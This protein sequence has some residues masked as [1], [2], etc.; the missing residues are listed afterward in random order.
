[1][2]E[3]WKQ[4]TFVDQMT[5]FHQ[6]STDAPSNFCEVLAIQMLGHAVGYEPANCLQPKEVKH[7]CY[8]LFIGESTI[9]RKSTTQDF[10]DDIY[11]PSRCAPNETSPEQ[12]IVDLSEKSE[13]F[14]FL[15][16]FSG[17]LK[18]IE[19]KGYMARFAEV[20]NDMHGCKARYVRKLR[21]R[22][23]VKNEFV[24]ENGYVSVNSTVTPSVLRQHLTEEI[25]VGGLLPRWLLVKGEPNV[26]P[27]DRLYP[28]ALK[29]KEVLRQNLEQLIAMEK[30]GVKFFLS[31]EALD[32]YRAIEKYSYKIY[33]KVLPFVGRYM[34]YVVSFADILLVSDAIGISIAHGKGL[35][36]YKQLIELI[37]LKSLIQ[38]DNNNIVVEKY[39]GDTIAD[40]VFINQYIRKNGINSSNYLIV[41]SGYIERAWNVIH[42]CLDYASILVDY[43]EL[44]TPVAKLMDFLKKEGKASHSKAMQ[45]THLNSTEMKVAV[46]T[47]RQRDEIEILLRQVERK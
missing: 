32:R 37:K 14:Q 3:E 25:M 4:F 27:R 8:T 26:R 9:T 38:L 28:D 29:I 39:S 20:Y 44:D 42:P 34:N 5:Q 43:V 17:I 15:G 1:M 18:G 22:K 16:E 2:E 46:E 41:S 19:G 24:I 31:D 12:F 6:L 13:L 35:H 23:G 45:Y 33:N 10:G 21:E 47:L 40:K 30:T 11:P 7:N 36:Q